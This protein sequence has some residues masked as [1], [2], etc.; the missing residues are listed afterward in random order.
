M[1]EELKYYLYLKDSESRAT[2]MRLPLDE[3]GIYNILNR[4]Y[5]TLLPVVVCNVDPECEL[6]GV[7]PSKFYYEIFL[8]C[9]IFDY[10]KE[11]TPHIFKY[12]FVK[13]QLKLIRTYRNFLM[14]TVKL[15]K[16]LLLV[17]Q[18]YHLILGQ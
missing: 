2:I 15:F 14:K 4:V 9:N 11:K 13:E 17:H 10:L 16:V 7:N 8:L 6:S 3:E 1:G 12:P 5:K 18:K